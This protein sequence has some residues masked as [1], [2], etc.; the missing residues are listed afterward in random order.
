MQKSI[1]FNLINETY[2]N[3]KTIP[4]AFVFSPQSLTRRPPKITYQQIDGKDL[5][6]LDDFFTEEEGEKMRQFTTTTTFS[7]KIYGSPEAKEKGELP[8]KAMN[9]SERWKFFAKPPEPIQALFEYFGYLGEKLDAQVTTLPWDLC[10]GTISSPAVATNFLVASSAT[11][12][13]E[14]KHK[15]FDPEKGLAFGIP[16]LHSSGEH[17]QFE[18]GAKGR[19]WMVTAMLYTTAPNF[20]PSF[21]LGTNFYSANNT[22]ASR[23]NCEN[24]RLVLFEGD[25]LHTIEQSF[26]PNDLKTWRVSYVFKLI[27]NP[28]NNVSLKG[29]I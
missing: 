16:N 23:A 7:R 10:S 13:E 27:I 28:N 25:I 1:K 11:S 2:N 6:L 4:L 21:G 14:G 24:M 22:L 18:N 9:A 15:D 19:P 20:D 8:A 5:Y 29:S 26:L 12:M 17:T 3:P